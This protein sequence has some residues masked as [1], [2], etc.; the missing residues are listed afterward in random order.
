MKKSNSKILF[1]TTELPYPLD[2][3]GKIRT[4]NMI[5]SIYNYYKID[6]VCFSEKKF[7]TEINELRKMCENIDII[8]KI[9]TNSNS[10]YILAKNLILSTF[11]NSPFIVEKFN[12]REFQ[13]K[14]EYLLKENEYEAII[15]DHL[16]MVNYVRNVKKN[17]IIL[18]QHNCEYLIL[19]RRYEKEEKLLKK[20]YIWNE[21]KKTKKYEKKM[22]KKVDKV[23]MLSKE[24]K[25][26]LID[27]DYSGT[28]I[29][30]LPISIENNFIKSTYNEK[31]NKILFLGTMSWFPNEQGVLWFIREVW[32][33]VKSEFPKSKL[34]VVGNKPSKE[35]KDCSSEDIIVTGYVD[36]VN[37][38]IELCDVCIIPLFI[39]GGMRVKILECMSKGIP[40][41]ST[42][43]GAEGIEYEREK[44]ILI[45]DSSDEFV[46]SLKNIQNRDKR[47]EM[48]NYGR[49]LIDKNYSLNVLTNGLIK[50]IKDEKGV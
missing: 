27:K 15:V 47:I 24:D 14:V 39:G 21:Y 11:K 18:S 29:S 10:K 17:K 3:G 5:K 30:I 35:I 16:Q 37:K 41:I 4:Y 28:N 20:L 19:K 13:E 42:S 31:I 1:L 26:F 36:D 9:Y 7:N 48:A 25:N 23:I 32:E 49:K 12:D 6:L 33:K 46:K 38:Y 22:C 50:I 45:A 44:N 40:C 2:N 34:Y 8:H 43:I